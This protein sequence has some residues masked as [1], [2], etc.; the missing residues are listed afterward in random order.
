MACLTR[1]TWNKP[2]PIACTYNALKDNA[3]LKSNVIDVIR[4]NNVGVK[5]VNVFSYKDRR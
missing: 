5:I 2:E 4:V 3:A 1:V